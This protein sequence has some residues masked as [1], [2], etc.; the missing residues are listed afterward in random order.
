VLIDSNIIIY[1]TKP[2]HDAI[3]GFIAEHVPA[4]SAVSYVEVLGYHKLTVQERTLLEAFFASASILALSE[5]VLNQA[6]KLRQLRK[7]S[8][9]D[10]LVAG[11]ALAHNLTLVTRNTADFD[12]IAGLSI[13]NPFTL[14][15]GADY[16][17][18]SP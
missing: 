18:R 5:P 4:V 16:A 13:L 3:R 7:M 12:W 14:N 11:T 1:A 9:G 17:R 8:L 6:V 15:S 2:E 10:A